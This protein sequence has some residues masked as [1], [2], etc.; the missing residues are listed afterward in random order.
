M[1]Y[2]KMITNNSDNRDR[3]YATMR[4][5]KDYGMGIL[6][7]AVALFM[8]APKIFGLGTVEVD[9]LFRY[10]FG[11]ICII[12]GSWRLYRGYRKDYFKP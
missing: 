2:D 11:G 9:P 1:S 3:R 5:I 8:F 7:L 4:S 6:Y 12:Y 10:I